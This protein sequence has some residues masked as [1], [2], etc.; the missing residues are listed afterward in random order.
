MTCSTAHAKGDPFLFGQEQNLQIVV[1]N[2]ILAKVNGKAISVVDVMKK[3]DI[4]FYRQFPEYTSSVNAR[5]QFYQANWKY[6]LHELIDKELILADAE[7]VKLPVTGGDV[8]QEM[9]TLF[10]PNI[11]VNLDKVGLSFDDAW[12]IVQGDITLR[13]MLFYRVNA[14]AIRNV[15]PQVIREAY[16]SFAKDNIRPDTWTYQVISIRDRDPTKGAEAALAAHQLL[17]EDGVSLKDLP[18]R[19]KEMKSVGKKTVITVSNDLQH[20]DKEVS[21]TYKDILSPLKQGQYSQPTAHKSRTDKSTVFRIFYLKDVIPGGLIPFGEVENDLKNKL[22]DEAITNESKLYL[23]K[24]RQHFDVHESHFKEMYSD[25][26]QP[27]MLK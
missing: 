7:E 3:M 23:D 14:K 22:L 4:L 17:T 12:K 19:A 20:T 9:E 18:D 6:I 1:N 16:E 11:I 13:R 15:T 8:R 24:L 21:Q 27:F 2:R 25:D 5:Y 10:G 26:F